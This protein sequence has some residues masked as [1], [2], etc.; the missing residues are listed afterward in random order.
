MSVTVTTGKSVI[1]ADGQMQTE[2][3]LSGDLTYTDHLSHTGDA[4]NTEPLRLRVVAL[5]AALT[6]KA[7]P[8]Q[9]MPRV[10]SLT[11]PRRSLQCRL[12]SS[13]RRRRPNWIG[14]RSAMRGARTATITSPGLLATVQALYLPAYEDLI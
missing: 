12:R 8:P 3:L 4:T 6:K 14:R 1:L 9:L 13:R 5:I 2:V 11:S 7:Q 10:P